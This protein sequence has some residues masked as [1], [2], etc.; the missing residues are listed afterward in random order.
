MSELLWTKSTT[1]SCL[2]AIY[3]LSLIK[4]KYFTALAVAISNSAAILNG[5][6]LG[7][8]LNWPETSS[9]ERTLLPTDSS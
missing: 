7:L 3:L 1:W 4:A 6:G 5:V 8:L 9:I 2:W